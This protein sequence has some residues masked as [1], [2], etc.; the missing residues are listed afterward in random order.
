MRALIAKAMRRAA[1]YLDPLGPL[2]DVVS[3][4]LSEAGKAMRADLQT[5]KR[6]RAIEPKHAEPL[7]GSLEARLEERDWRR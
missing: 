5:A 4:E 6:G 1:D 2:D 7:Q 3:V